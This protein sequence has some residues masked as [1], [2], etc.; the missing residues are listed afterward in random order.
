MVCKERYFVN[1]IE[2]IKEYN[3]IDTVYDYID[4]YQWPKDNLCGI[5]L[6]G[7]LNVKECE[8]KHYDI[9]FGEINTPMPIEKINKYQEGILKNI[10]V[11]GNKD[12]GFNVRMKIKNGEEELVLEFL[13][14][15]CN[16]HFLRYRGIDYTNVF[17]TDRYNQYVREYLLLEN[18]K[19]F[20]GECEID[21]EDGI[22]IHQK[23]YRKVDG[24]R[25]ISLYRSYIKKDGG[26]C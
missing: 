3:I 18:E 11:E 17:G 15:N 4:C 6:H 14:G 9:S 8:Y 1:N 5:H 21:I 16:F 23:S 13:C 10:S 26:Y 24:I 22:S 25:H 7:D 19:Y 2:M 12:D 20:D